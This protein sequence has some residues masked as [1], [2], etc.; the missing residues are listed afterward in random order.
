MT[1]IWWNNGENDL[2]VCV[3]MCVCFLLLLRILML[4]TPVFVLINETPLSVSY[5]YT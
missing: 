1:G 3:C 2:C 4:E 5:D